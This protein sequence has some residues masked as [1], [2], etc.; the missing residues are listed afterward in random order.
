[1]DEAAQ[2]EQAIALSLADAGGATAGTEDVRIESAEG[3]AAAPLA[4][5]S[6]RGHCLASAMNRAST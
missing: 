1:M 5:Q 6:S 4:R 2:I 3:D